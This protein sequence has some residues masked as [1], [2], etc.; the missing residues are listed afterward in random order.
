MKIHELYENQ[1]LNAIMDQQGWPADLQAEMY[2]EWV[3]KDPEGVPFVKSLKLLND[4]AIQV[5]T[6][7]LLSQRENLETISRTPQQ[8]I[9]AINKKWGLNVPIG[10]Q[11][12]QNP[13]RYFKYAQMSSAT[14]KPSIMVDGEI[15]MG[16]GRFI[17]ALLREDD[18][19]RVWN[20]TK[21]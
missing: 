8:V 4:T 10:N 7:K 13:D 1:N 16:L 9:D 15:I 20:F 2:D 5:P 11:Y 17:A 12:D 19:I 14:A 6:K 3:A 21:N 18:A